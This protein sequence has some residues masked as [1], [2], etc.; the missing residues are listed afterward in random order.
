MRWSRVV[1]VTLVAVLSTN[2]LPA[3]AADPPPTVTV[4]SNR[5]TYV[6]GM[7]ASV[8]VEVQNGNN[9]TLNVK[10]QFANGKTA[11]VSCGGVNVN[12]ATFHC[13]LY[14]LINTRI[15]ATIGGVSDDKLL[16]VRPSMSSFPTGARAYQNG[17]AIYFR[18]DEPLVR[19]TVTPSRASMCIRH[20]VEVLRASGWKSLLT[21]GC[22]YPDPTR[23]QVLWR[24]YGD[25]PTGYQFRVRATFGGDKLNVAGP[26]TWAYLRFISG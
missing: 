21:G 2:A 15:V 12:D 5:T 4:T 11:T 9:G 25:H 23:N 7:T 13:S 10:A 19:T 18:G 16:L 3:S 8:T 22:K 24:W 20:Q 14:V 1:I 26:G 6:A 17:K